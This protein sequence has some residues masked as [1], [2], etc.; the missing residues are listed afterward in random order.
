MSKIQVHVLEFFECHSTHVEIVLKEE[1]LDGAMYYNIDRWAS[2]KKEASKDNKTYLDLLKRANKNLVFEID[3]NMNDIIEKWDQKY[4]SE[5]A[6]ICC[7]NCADTTAWFLETFINIPNPGNCSKPITCNYVYLGF[8][9]PSFLQCCTVPGRVMDYAEKHP[10]KETAA[11]SF[12]P[13]RV[14]M[15]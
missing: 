15:E 4:F 1:T 12:R 9:A 10:Q 11:L 14:V 13:K 5:N 3:G 7:N 8:F 6:N 2:P